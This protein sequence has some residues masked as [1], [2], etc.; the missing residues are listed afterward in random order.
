MSVHITVGEFPTQTPYAPLAVLGHCLTQSRF[1]SPVW[2]SLTWPMKTREHQ[3]TE[4][5]TDDS[6]E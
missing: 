1:L 3:P 2:E 5:L 6:S 4:K